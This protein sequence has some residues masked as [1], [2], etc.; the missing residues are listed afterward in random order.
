MRMWMVN[1]A[2][3]CNKHLLGEH[4]E[5]HM[6]VGHLQRKRRIT[7]YIKLNLL[8]PKS[9]R[10]RHIQLAFEMQSRNML[11][12]SPLPEFDLSY[13]PEEHKF[14]TVDADQ[15]LIELSRRCLECRERLS[16]SNCSQEHA[17]SHK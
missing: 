13:L 7:N 3:M 10:E 9:L 15:S 12:K 6:L 14:Y 8:Q 1:P 4:V 11:H 16:V 2:L 5:C 17:N